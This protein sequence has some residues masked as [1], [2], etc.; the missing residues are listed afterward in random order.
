MLKVSS[1]PYQ[2]Q[3]HSNQTSFKALKGTLIKLDYTG[4]PTNTRTN[5]ETLLSNNFI[6]NVV[7]TVRKN[8]G[9]KKFFERFDGY[10]TFRGVSKNI[11]KK[12]FDKVEYDIIYKSPD[13]D[14]VYH[15]G[16]KT[17]DSETLNGKCCS[18]KFLEDVKNT[19]FDDLMKK[20]ENEKTRRQKLAK[21]SPHA[22]L[23]HNKN[24]KIAI[25]D[26]EKEYKKCN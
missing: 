23:I 1:H 20:H 16:H 18:E 2:R 4:K 13:E 5:N 22:E 7:K 11:E 25:N 12:R 17:K 10:L 14:R 26:I 6:E 24:L 3:N 9:I 15:I 19:T 21:D 8:E